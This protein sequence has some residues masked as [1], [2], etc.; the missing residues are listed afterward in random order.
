MAKIDPGF[1]NLP[2]N[3]KFEIFENFGFLKFPNL[4]QLKI[5]NLI[6]PTTEVGKFLQI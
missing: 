1:Q 4:F 2:K 6:L 3:G 5:I